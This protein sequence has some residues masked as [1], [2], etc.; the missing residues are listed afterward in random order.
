MQKSSH[1]V[2]CYVYTKGIQLKA[3]QVQLKCPPSKMSEM[4]LSLCLIAFLYVHI[5]YNA[6]YV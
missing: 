2:Q 6:R 5:F 3:T 1:C 4:K